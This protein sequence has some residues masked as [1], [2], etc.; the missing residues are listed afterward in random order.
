MS[1]YENLGFA[2]DDLVLELEPEYDPDQPFSPTHP[3]FQVGDFWDRLF[4]ATEAYAPDKI[5]APSAWSLPGEEDERLSRNIGLEF[6]NADLTV[7]TQAIKGDVQGTYEALLGR[8]RLTQAP[9]YGDK[10]GVSLALTS[11]GLGTAML[12]QCIEFATYWEIDEPNLAAMV[13]EQRVYALAGAV[14]GERPAQLELFSRDGPEWDDSLMA[15]DGPEEV[16]Y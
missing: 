11:H 4:Y 7:L 13:E 16:I 10:G 5:R 1:A 15:W 8:Y 14:E 3:F 12:E 6:D 9:R 2:Y